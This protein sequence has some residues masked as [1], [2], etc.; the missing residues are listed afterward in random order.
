MQQLG[1]QKY[2]IQGG[3]LGSFIARVMVQHYQD[4]IGG[5]LLNAVALKEPT[6]ESHPDLWERIQE[7]PLT[8]EEK[9]GLEQNPEFLKEGM[10]YYQIQM[11]K[12]L[13]LGY[14]INDSPI[15]LLAWIYEKLHDWS[16]SYPW[17]DDEILTWACIYYFSTAG[18]NAS[19][20]IYYE[21]THIHDDP[22]GQKW[23]SVPF[24]MSRFPKELQLHPRLWHEQLGP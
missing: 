10:G 4:S 23:S 24:G 3:D 6:K 1:Y 17:T 11:T 5:H 20:Q 2:I 21:A 15:G 8:D 7:T 18:P 12:P 13:T 14:S 19:Q 16:D 22:P 9:R